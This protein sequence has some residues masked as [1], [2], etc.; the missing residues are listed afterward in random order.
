MHVG[1]VW[2]R[3]LFTRA[4][5]DLAREPPGRVPSDRL[6]RRL[7][8]GWGNEDW[9]AHLAYL[10]AVCVFASDAGGPILECGSGLTTVLIGAMCAEGAEPIS[11]E[12][13]PEWARRVNAALARHGLPGRV[14]HRPL[15][16]YEGFDW[17]EPSF[18]ADRF[19]FRLVICDGPPG[20]TEG[21]RYGLLPLCRDHLAAEWVILADDAERPGDAAVLE[22]WKREFGCTYRIES[23]PDADFAVIRPAGR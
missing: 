1:D 23:G 15:Q 13:S 17:Y 16:S 4:M 18:L 11:V 19:G 5:R 22:R 7:R 9:S 10:R 14:E 6:L 2:R 21:G 20:S 12:H 8:R 3:F